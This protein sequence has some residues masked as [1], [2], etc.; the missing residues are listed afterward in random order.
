MKALNFK[1][2]AHLRVSDK[3]IDIYFT[4]KMKY[5]EFERRWRDVVFLHRREKFGKETEWLSVINF[6]KSLI[7]A[8]KYYNITIDKEKHTDYFEESSS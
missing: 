1:Y 8:P 3:D 7:R 6:Y 4:N 2:C 5:E